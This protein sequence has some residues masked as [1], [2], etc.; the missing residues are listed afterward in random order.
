MAYLRIANLKKTYRVSRTE[1]Q[2][3]LKGVNVEF[4][5]GELVAMLG[6]SGCGKST[7]INILGGLDNDYTGSVVLNGEFFKDYTEKQLDDYRKSKVGLI[8]QSYNL[9]NHM[10]VIENVEIAMTMSNYSKEER[11]KTA[12]AL[13]KDMEIEQYK[14]KLPNQLSGGQKQRVAI[15]RALAN[16]P[17]IILADE[18]T[19]A[20]DKQSADQVLDILKKIAESGKLVILVTHSHKIASSCSRIITLDDGIIKSDEKLCDL[21]VPRIKPK[22]NKAHNISIKELFKLAYNNLLQ[23]K[24][25]SLLVSIGM[26]IGIAAVILVFCVSSGVTDYVKDKLSDSMNALQIEVSLNDGDT[27]TNAYTDKISSIEGVDY[28]VKGSYTKL[29]SSY[30]FGTN[31]SG[32]IMML[33]SSFDEL[34]KSLTAGALP[35]SGQIAINESFAE[36]LY[37]DY[38]DEADELVGREITITFSETSTETCTISG[39]YEDESDYTDYPCAYIT[40]D[41]LDTLFKAAD[42]T[43]KTTVLY[44]YCDSVDYVD[45]VKSSIEA[46]GFTAV[47]DDAT[48]ETAISYIDVGT[49]VLTAFSAIAVI[50]SAIMIF[51]VM[52]ISIIERTKEI[53]V[54]RAVGARKK[55]IKFMFI[56]EAG[57][58]GFG[59]GIIAVILSAAI[60]ICSNLILNGLYD[61]KLINNNILY[62]VIGLL[63]S[64]VI[65]IGAGF[66]PALQAS[67][68][69]PVDSLRHE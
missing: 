60:G 27:I 35:T 64:V 46:L 61:F 39:V 68:L 13:L 45:A 36:T 42:K 49:K 57:L 7:L 15:A 54:L 67:E 19:G 18:P 43:L 26:S 12:L 11:N 5:R 52:Y 56:F 2:E 47:R 16:N 3:V 33:N 14:N 1:N 66:S 48:A 58:L 23:T 31:N 41:D 20:L 44:V 62:Y 51:I 25:R 30:K 55:D 6:E 38:V 9:I 10:T 22:S 17:E 29:N 34:E 50:V 4:K 32:Y 65:S 21:E 24:N 28:T 53:G 37:N 40:Y 59:S 63:V 69:E 8:F